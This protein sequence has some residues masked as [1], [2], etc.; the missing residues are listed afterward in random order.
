MKKILYPLLVC[1]L[2]ACSKKDTQTP[3][4]APVAVTEVSSYLSGV[5]SLSE[6]EVA[7]KKINLSTAEASGGITVFAPGNEA[8]G[9]FN[10]GARTM[11]KDLP[12]SVIKDHIVKGL[13]KAADLTD[14]KQLTTL[15]GKILTVK[16]VDGKI[17]VNNVLITMED[18]KAG[19]QV[20]HTV[21]QM[22]S[23]IPGA[24]DVTV[25]DATLWS[26]N[27]RNGQLTAS[28]TVNLYLSNAESPAFTAMTDNSGMAH[29][30][31]LPAATYYVVVKK[32][33]LSNQWPDANGHTYMSLDTLFQSQADISNSNP[34][35]YSAGIGDFRF[36]DLNQDGIV[37]ANDKGTAPVRA[38]IVENG[39]I[40]AQKILIGYEKNSAMKLF[41]N[42]AD[43]QLSLSNVVRQV[44]T[45]HKSL[46][47]LDGIMS[48]DADCTA[49]P[50]WCAYDQF[51]FTASDNKVY[52]IW[53][54]EYTAITAL[55]RIILSLPQ[56][57][58]TSVIAAQA[59]A[60]RAY[61]YL[62]MATYFGGLPMYNGLVMP[63][64]IRRATLEATYA[65]IQNELQ[66][67]LSTLPATADVHVVT[68]G[69]AKILLAR[70]ALA[71]GNFSAAS[72]YAVEV[73]QSNYSL[74]NSAEIYT[75]AT[76]S[77]I[78][79]DL[80]DNFPYDFF[81]YW[82]HT[83]CPVARISEAHLIRAEADIAMGNLNSGG[84]S[85]TLIRN[86]SNM[87]LLSMM[88]SDEARAALVDT[89]K[90]E[91]FKEGL[92]FRNLVRWQLAAQVLTPKGYMP[93]RSLLPVPLNVLDSDPNMVQNPGY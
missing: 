10:I 91:F 12:D 63:A 37:N 4:A 87:P 58:D 40:T 23:T 64:D 31:G 51:T 50:D 46:V 28:A 90:N 86:R 7:F 19:E 45:T 6:F 62:E 11:G 73:I 22:L 67:A 42:L 21:A 88:N 2:F 76:S 35:Q 1:G 33:D 14:G 81:N 84:A 18:G 44:G 43:A 39:A 74:V 52:D 17:Y 49:S 78:V 20:V 13:F 34:G 57:G 54:S 15:N 85:I 26:E 55:N 61:V 59:R 70:I 16:V 47:M 3:P 71:T 38:I 9:G 36:A 32:G 79:W 5:D 93:Y 30:T 80:S 69:A 53:T 8:I 75:S 68:K 92:R 89:Y 24:I 82:S 77:E 60:M 25:Y 27:N 83:F 66:I 65:F 48:D 56:I 29:F 72:T 41:T